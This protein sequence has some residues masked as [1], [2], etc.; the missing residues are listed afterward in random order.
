M[1]R[2]SKIFVKVSTS[3]IKKRNLSTHKEI[4]FG[5]DG[6]AAM[7]KGIDILANAVAV[8]LGPK[9]RNVII[10]QPYGAPKITKDGVT[11][12]KAITLQDKFENLGAKL[13]QD[14]ANKTNEI[15]GDGTTTATV[16]ARAIFSEGLKSM[17]YGINPSELRKGVQIAVNE[18]IEFLKKNSTKITTS[19]QISQV[20]TISANGDSH[21][22][23]LI[24][25]AMSKVG[26]EGVITVQDG[27]I[28][29]DELI[30]TEGMQF[31]R[32]YISPYFVNDTKAQKVQLEN[33]YILLCEKK[34]SLFQDIFPIL[35]KAARE[36]RPLLII[37]EDIEGDALAGLI[38][39]KIQSK[40]SVCAVKAPGFGDNRKAIL[41]DIAVVTGGVVFNEEYFTKLQDADTG[42]FGTAK[43]VTV[44]KDNTILL[45]GGGT[46][47]NIHERSELLREAIVKT[48]SDYE[49]EK[50][51]ER[52][53]KISGGV[54]VIK[55]GGCSEVE[56]GEKKDRVVDALNATRAAVEEGF[57]PGGGSALIKAVPILRQ[58]VKEEKN[59]SV[60]IGI[61]I[62]MEA[63][64]VPLRTIIDNAGGH[65]SDVANELLKATDDFSFGFDASTGKYVNMLEQGIIDPLKVVRTALNDAAGVASL[66]TTT[67]AMIVD[68]PTSES[69]AMGRMGGGMGGM[70][71]MGMDM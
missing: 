44:T 15:A 58:L 33:P 51:Q 14:V 13:V 66:L 27:K 8:T 11:V 28:M 55:V 45:N 9:G 65:G 26:K 35:E 29:E 63:I 39:N 47:E 38:I 23:K 69:G 70:G 3:N 48:T 1:L 16:L 18:V 50:L 6:R 10:E 25:T 68:A 52:L 36:R 61:R 12:A 53:A 42:S 17:Y 43:S 19:E 31:D 22:G 67:D 37:A 20:A 57:I 41:E 24:S 34:I 21:I 2:S 49:K 7:A 30:V 59:A 54:A 60:A 64:Q 32:G 5:I 71:G 4:K 40:V 56:V 62:I 46:T